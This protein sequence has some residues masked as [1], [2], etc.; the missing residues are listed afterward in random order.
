MLTEEMPIKG[1]ADWRKCQLRNVLTEKNSDCG[2][3]DWKKQRLRDMLS[4]GM[5]TEGK[6]DR[7]NMPTGVSVM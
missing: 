4:E 7:G 2:N 5:P 3:A 1:N 6:A